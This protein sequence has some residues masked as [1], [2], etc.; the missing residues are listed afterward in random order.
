MKGGPGGDVEGHMGLERT[1]TSRVLGE[2]PRQA[3]K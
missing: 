1:A 2:S 3:S